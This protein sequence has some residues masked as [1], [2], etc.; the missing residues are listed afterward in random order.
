MNNLSR[1]FPYDKRIMLNVIYDTMD[2]L[3][4]LIEKSNSERG[5]IIAISGTKPYTRIRIACSG[6]LSEGEETIIQICPEPG[7][8]AGKRLAGVML[9]EISATVKRTLGFKEDMKES[10]GK[11]ESI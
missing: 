10:K 5:T 2:M 3:G 7:D 4:F 1:M 11:E 6:I 9:D 8:D